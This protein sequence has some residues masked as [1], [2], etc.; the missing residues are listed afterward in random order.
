MIDPQKIWS[1]SQLPTLPSVAIRL[2]ELSQDPETEFPLRRAEF[3]ANW[4]ES[5]SQRQN[6]AEGRQT[7]VERYP[8]LKDFYNEND[9]FVVNNKDRNQYKEFRD[10]LET[11]ER[12]ALDRAIKAG[13]HVHFVDFHNLGGLVTPLPLTLTFADGSTEEY[14]VPAEVWRYN[15]EKVTKLFIRKQRL[16]S[17]EL[18]RSHLIADADK[19][20]N[21]TPRRIEQ[22]RIELFKGR[23][24]GRNQ[25][26]DALAELK[27][28]PKSGEK[29]EPKALPLQPAQPK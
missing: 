17:V 2:L 1:S 6:R 12:T 7:R 20:N 26:L 11:W 18:D 21:I 10:K 9:P 14:Q 25:M 13:E 5:Y 28:E 22:S 15:A 24:S 29:T 27:G 19:S 3:A 16:V 4:P 8:E 23:D